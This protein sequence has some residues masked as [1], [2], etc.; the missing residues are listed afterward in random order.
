VR[1]ARDYRAERKAAGRSVPAD[2]AL[3]EAAAE[4]ADKEA[5]SP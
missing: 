3:I 2:I 1:M 4:A 5:P